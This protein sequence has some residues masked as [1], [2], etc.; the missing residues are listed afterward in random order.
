MLLER[1]PQQRGPI[2]V[3]LAGRAVRCPQDLLVE[4]DLDDFDDCGM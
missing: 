3:P 1:L 4:N 2:A